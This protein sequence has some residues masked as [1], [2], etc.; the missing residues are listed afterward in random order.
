[1]SASMKDIKTAYPK[2]W[3]APCRSP[4]PWSWSR[5]SKLRTA[6]ERAERSAALSLICCTRRMSDVVGGDARDFDSLYTCERIQRK[7]RLYIV[8]AGDRG[9]AGGYNANV[10]KLADPEIES[11]RM[12]HCVH[13]HRQ[14]ESCEH[15][16][17]RTLRNSRT[18]AF[19]GIAE[20]LTVDGAFRNFQPDQR[21]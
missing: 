5:P 6:K 19:A 13:S 16:E 9:L 15:F 7:S 3:K 4:R 10:F 17:R 8:I 11:A 12:R 2:R 14:K 21:G 18:T 1:M 20:E